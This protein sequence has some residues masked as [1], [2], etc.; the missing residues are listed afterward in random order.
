MSSSPD[1]NGRSRMGDEEESDDEF[2]EDPAELIK[3]FGNHPLMKR[4]Q[5][6]LLTQLKDTQSRLDGEIREKDE[7]VKRL[8]QDREVLGVQLYSFQQQLAKLQ[9]TLENAHNEF[10]AIVDSKLQEDDLLKD[11]EGNNFEQK[12]LYDEHRKQLKKYVQELDSLTETLR[13]VEQYNEEM[14]SEIEVTRRATYKAEQSMQN[15]EK[16]KQSQDAYVDNLNSKIK[17][18][19]EQI[20]VVIAQQGMQKDESQEANAVL[21]ETIKELEL[22]A[23]EK[24]QLMT[25]WKAALAGLSRRDEALFQAS[26]TLA[27]AEAAVHD[28]DVEI[29][30][31]KRDI[32]KEQS[33]HEGLV[34]NRDKLENELQWV[35]D[36]VAKAKL[37]REQLQERYAMLNK[38]FVQ[39]ESDSKK[40]D[41]QS[42]QL[43][44]D[45]E[46]LLQ[47]LMIVAR[48]RQRVE[49]EVQLTLSAQSNVTKAVQNLLKDQS[50]ILKRIH[51]RENESSDIENEIARTRVDALNASSTNDQL[52]EQLGTTS[53]E[54]QDKDSLVE[55]YQVEI[56]QRNDEIEKKMYRVDRLNKK[57]EKMVESAGGEENLGPMENVVKNLGREIEKI[58]DDCKELEREWL[59]KQ[60]ELV[61][62]SSDGDKVHDENN[63]LQ[64]RVTIFTQKKLRTTKELHTAKCEVKAA[65]QMDAEL[66]KDIA[67]LNALISE[68]QTQEGGL[69][70]ENYVLEM[71]CVEELRQLEKASVTLRGD[72]AELRSAKAACLEEIMDTERQ[73]LLWEKKIQ[74]DKETREALDPTVG[75]AENSTMEKEI[76]RMTLRLEALKR[77]QERLSVELENAVNKRATI[78]TRYK[79]KASTGSATSEPSSTRTSSSLDLTQ[80]SLKKRVGTL[81]R[82]AKELSEQTQKYGAAIEERRAALSEMTSELERVTAQYG[83][84]E[85]INHS[86]QSEINDLLYQKQL[87]QERLTYRQ[88]YVKKLKELSQGGGVE[89]SQALQVERK[90]LSASQALEN[91]KEIIYDLQESHPHLQEVLRRVV[92][93]ADPGIEFNNED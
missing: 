91:V 50:K 15:L 11:I 66:Q 46:A 74:L 71:E 83:E 24:K 36:A 67:K 87:G 76:H 41:G 69:Q 75:Q 26:Q 28:F 47:S 37:E 85:E 42:K 54:L 8:T 55:K 14:K 72:I 10:N 81:K 35:E 68:N 65:N 33:K 27:N 25:Q 19:K 52:K 79:A 32:L 61:Q 57:Y 82:D 53:K 31:V 59:K 1:I 89:P 17:S 63:E 73:A 43:K 58:D 90:L 21:Q 70:N 51:E 39:T 9:V 62:L 12:A 38:S 44:I 49:E 45:G 30:T 78:A 88:K 77:E 48:E 29:E 5:K 18:F 92:T 16:Y 93:M 20:A 13:Q 84:T 23:N 7:E 4:A 86:L 40:L 22:I 6:A 64:A 2:Y 3:E 56:R 60:T 34:N 80:A